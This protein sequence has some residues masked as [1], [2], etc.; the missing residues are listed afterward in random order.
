MWRAYPIRPL[1]SLRFPEARCILP[2]A[3]RGAEER[4]SESPN[5]LFLD[6]TIAFTDTFT[7]FG[8][9]GIPLNG[10]SLPCVVQRLLT[11]A[12]FHLTEGAVCRSH[13]PPPPRG[14]GTYPGLILRNIRSLSPPCMGAHMYSSQYQQ[15]DLQVVGQI[16][17]LAGSRAMISELTV[18]LASTSMGLQILA[19]IK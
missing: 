6:G 16:Y 10:S 7:Q 11:T 18:R 17:L 2:R 14:L 12:T 4:A 1:P 13:I 19:T 15:A 5:L 9:V 8:V 3:A